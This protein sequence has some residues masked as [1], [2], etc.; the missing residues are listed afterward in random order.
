MPRGKNEDAGQIE[1]AGK[2][3]L[4]AEAGEADRGTAAGRYTGL[5]RCSLLAFAHD[6]QIGRGIRA[7]RGAQ[8]EVRLQEVVAVLALLQFGGERITG[9]PGSRSRG[10]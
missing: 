1:Q 4:I 5:Q 10:A 2:L 8:A 7:V 3:A 6:D 9:R